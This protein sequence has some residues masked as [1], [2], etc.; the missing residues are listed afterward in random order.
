MSFPRQ[1]LEPCIQRPYNS[2]ALAVA[3]S[4]ELW[5]HSMRVLQGV[6]ARQLFSVT[7]MLMPWQNQADLSQYSPRQ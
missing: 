1:N 2:E 6:T 5:M 3:C 7:S 4:A